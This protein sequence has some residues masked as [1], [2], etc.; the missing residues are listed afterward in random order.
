MN[1]P[2]RTHCI[3]GDAPPIGAVSLPHRTMTEAATVA[4][5]RSALV[6]K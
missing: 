2:E 3:R 4:L 5:D 1:R 6:V